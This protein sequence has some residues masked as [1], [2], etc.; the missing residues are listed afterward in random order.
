[1]NGSWCP[2]IN[3][4]FPQSLRQIRILT[5][6]I[7]P[8]FCTGY[9]NEALKPL[10]LKRSWSNFDPQAYYLYGEDQNCEASFKDKGLQ[11]AVDSWCK[12]KVL[13][14][15]PA[16]NP[17]SSGTSSLTLR[18]PSHFLMGTNE[19]GA[20]FSLSRVA[21]LNRLTV[22]RKRFIFLLFVFLRN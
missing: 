22:L 14:Y 16:V 19:L 7:L 13:Q 18:K 4:Y 3:G 2:S 5:L 15:I 21:C 6:E 8:E 1:L 9:R 12:I 20:A 10:C 11:A 17:A